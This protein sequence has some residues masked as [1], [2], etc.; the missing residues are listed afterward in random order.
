M[1]KIVEFTDFAVTCV[2]TFMVCVGL[3][4]LLENGFFEDNKNNKNKKDNW[5]EK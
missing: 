2:C 4:G 3:F 1:D 5:W